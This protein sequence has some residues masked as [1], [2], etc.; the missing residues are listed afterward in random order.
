MKS[1]V[2]DEICP[3]GQVEECRLAAHGIGAGPIHY[4]VKMQTY[5]IIKAK[6]YNQFSETT[7]QALSSDRDS[8]R[9]RG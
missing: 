3:Y 9:R 6:I 2:P 4:G 1:A 5:Y 8:T 7:R